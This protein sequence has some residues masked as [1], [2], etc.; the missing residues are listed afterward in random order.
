MMK[1]Y[2]LLAC[3]FVCL[4]LSTLLGAGDG[5]G[6]DFDA[7]MVKA[8]AENKDVLLEFT[9]SD[10]CPP[11]KAL[12]E[13]IT[14]T[15]EFMT[16]AKE[17]FI[18]VQLDFPKNK[19][20]TKAVKLENQKI[21]AKYKIKGYPTILLCDPS[22]Q[23]YGKTGL[24]RVT[25]PAYLEHLDKMREAKAKRNAAFALAEEAT[26]VEKAKALNEGLLAMGT[27]IPSQFYQS[28]IKQ[29]KE[30]DPNME[31]Q[32][33]EPETAKQQADK[34]M[35]SVMALLDQL[36]AMGGDNGF[37]A[38]VSKRLMSADKE[39]SISICSDIDTYLADNPDTDSIMQQKMLGLKAQSSALQKD[40]ALFDKII[41]DAIAVDPESDYVSRL[42]SLQE[43]NQGHFK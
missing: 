35:K 5:W 18:L 23:V 3:L 26:G 8:K 38:G 22:G 40:K 19:P 41:E 17:K 27:E 37:M 28:T 14:G 13:T 20:Q 36:E 9:G 1:L 7:A 43:R 12:N 10:W 21:S 34:R 30:L 2:C 29:I 39:S 16:A 42:K 4:Q 15:E 6:S 33:P 24:K 32:F 31:L 25:V 11:C